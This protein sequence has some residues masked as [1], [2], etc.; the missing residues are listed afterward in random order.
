MKA[1]LKITTVKIVEIDLEKLREDAGLS[2]KQLSRLSGVSFGQ[3]NKAENGLVMTERF[4][5]K[6][7]IYI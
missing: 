2:L 5:N 1:K 7:K 6:L 3:I 4:W